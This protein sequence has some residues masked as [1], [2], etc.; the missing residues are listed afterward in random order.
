[1]RRTRVL[2]EKEKGQQTM[3]HK[4][5]GLLSHVSELQKAS[6]K[7]S[8]GLVYIK[9]LGNVCVRGNELSFHLSTTYNSHTMLYLGY[10]M[11]YLG[12]L[13]AYASSM[14]SAIIGLVKSSLDVYSR[15]WQGCWDS[16]AYLR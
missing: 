5:D 13:H 15:S 3:E 14:L 11:L 8:E 12:Y 9:A 10:P 16:M 1:M 7:P 4:R 6:N 2:S